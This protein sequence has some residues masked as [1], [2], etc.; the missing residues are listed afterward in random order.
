MSSLIGT[1]VR[2]SLLGVFLL[3]LAGI[4]LLGCV[5]RQENRRAVAE[6]PAMATPPIPPIDAAAPAKTET[7]TFAMG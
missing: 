1:L 7:A 2:P 3:G 6:A 4:G 5:A